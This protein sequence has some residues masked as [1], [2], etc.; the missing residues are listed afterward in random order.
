ME[1]CLIGTHPSGGQCTLG[2]THLMSR[3]EGVTPFPISEKLPVPLD[4]SSVNHHDPIVP[5]YV[6]IHSGLSGT[7]AHSQSQASSGVQCC[8][9]SCG[10]VLCAEQ[11]LAT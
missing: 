6:E 11:C 5:H 3:H 1:L 7:S 10:L 4:I 9:R 2:S 8:G